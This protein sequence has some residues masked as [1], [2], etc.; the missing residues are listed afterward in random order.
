M[1]T[2]ILNELKV[3]ERLKIVEA[4]VEAILKSL[5]EMVSTSTLAERNQKRRQ[6]HAEYEYIH[7]DIEEALLHEIET[8]PADSPLKAMS[9]DLTKSTDENV[10]LML[11]RFSALRSK[12]TLE[13]KPED[14]S[15]FERA[16]MA[17]RIVTFAV[18]FFGGFTLA[19]LL[20]PLR[21]S[22]ILLRKL[23]VKNSY[24]PIDLVQWV[25]S[26]A[27]C[28]AGGIQ[29]TTEGLEN[30]R[31]LNGKSTVMMFSHGSNWDGLMIQGTSPVTLKFIGKKSMFL[32]P[33]AGWA[34]RW[35]FGNL[36]IDRSNRERAKKSL[37][38]LARAVVDYNRSIAISP[39]GTRSKTGLL[40]DFKKGPFYLQSDAGVDITPVII[41]GAYELWPPARVFTLPGKCLVR[42]LPQ[43]N[44][45]PNKSRNANR[46]ALRRIYLTATAEPVPS[47]LSSHVDFPN[48]L[49]HIY[50][51]VFIWMFFPIAIYSIIT[52][53]IS[54]CALFGLSTF[55][56]FK[57]FMTI[58]AI[59]ES[60]MFYFNC[61][62][63]ESTI[64]RELNVDARLS[65]VEAKIDAFLASQSTLVAS[66]TLAQRNQK[67]RELHTESEYILLDIEE[68]LLHEIEK[69]DADSPLKTMNDDITM[70]KDE[71]MIAAVQRFNEIR[72]KLTLEIQPEDK[73]TFEKAYMAF[74]IVTFAVL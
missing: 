19:F 3:D 64:L 1:E 67:R 65:A 23:G 32:I 24:L 41:T 20:I 4:K 38:Y 33:V 51:L 11:K 47:D 53:F 16:Y 7:L 56:A 43:Y 59:L 28:T 71:V 34:F 5:P 18:L 57:L 54:F 30:V 35:C 40:Q 14:N 55:G 39:E 66:T 12:L 17:F 10:V 69:A 45:D 74:R 50:L 26:W 63:M 8:A 72:K 15:L 31:N 44:V 58:F 25:F 73:S 42:Y 48:L 36:P 49:H 68:A 21:W 29:I 62:L 46:L 37:K 70:S 6:L 9:D 22:H 2:K 61:P 13:I 27:M 60:I 52:Y